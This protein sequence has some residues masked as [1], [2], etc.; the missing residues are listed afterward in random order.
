MA[1]Y[2][3]YECLRSDSQAQVRQSTKAGK[4]YLRWFDS[5]SM[6]AGCS[7]EDFSINEGGFVTC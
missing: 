4:F 3:I 6:V 2:E 1:G 5:Q 7:V